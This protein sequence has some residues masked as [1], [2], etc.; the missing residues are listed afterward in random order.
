MWQNQLHSKSK[1]R[2]LEALVEVATHPDALPID[3]A[4]CLCSD[5]HS[6]FAFEEVPGFIRALAAAKTRI[7]GVNHLG[8]FRYLSQLHRSDPE[9]YTKKVIATLTFIETPRAAKLIQKLR[10]N[11]PEHLYKWIDST[12]ADLLRKKVRRLP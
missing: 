9:A 4:R 3:L 8:T 10:K 5:D 2:R 12:S 1:K 11:S 7:N 6:L